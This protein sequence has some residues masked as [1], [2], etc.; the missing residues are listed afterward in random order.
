[1]QNFAFRFFHACHIVEC[2]IIGE[3]GAEIQSLAHLFYPLE[4]MFLFH[5]I[6]SLCSRQ[7][8]GIIT[9]IGYLGCA[10]A[11]RTACQFLHIHVRIVVGYA[12]EVEVEELHAVFPFGETYVDLAVEATRTYECLVDEFHSVG[13]CH[14]YHAVVGAVAVHFHEQLVER[15][16][17]LAIAILTAADSIYFIDKDNAR[18]LFFCITEEFAH[19]AHA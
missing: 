10:K 5:H 16:F 4:Q 12:I 3:F 11:R 9:H 1:M 7:N 19:A 8:S 14:H 2:Y 18:G 17:A 13:G 6:L 15:D